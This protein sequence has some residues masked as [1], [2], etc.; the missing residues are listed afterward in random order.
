MPFVLDLSLTTE[1][2]FDAYLVDQ[3]T[4]PGLVPST[5]LTLTNLTAVSDGGDPLNPNTTIDVAGNNAEGYI[6]G[7]TVGYRRISFSAWY[8]ASS[9]PEISLGG[10]TTIVAFLTSINAA[11]GTNLVAA[12]VVDG[13]IVSDPYP[14]T[15]DVTF[16]PTNKIWIPETVTITISQ[17]VEVLGDGNGNALGDG[18]GNAIAVE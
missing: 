14:T 18:S 12:D 1:A 6:G 7:K 17:P 16:A 15:V 8:A 5:D 10:A 2:A 4:D 11:M 13:A 3:S 9:S